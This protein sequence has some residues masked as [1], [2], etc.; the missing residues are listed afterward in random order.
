MVILATIGLTLLLTRKIA[1]P[2][3]AI[4]EEAKHLP[5]GEFNPDVR[6][7]QYREAAELNATL[8]QAAA[9]IKK[10]DKAKRDLI[11]NVS[12]APAKDACSG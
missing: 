5:S 9:D 4:N 11:A 1:K 8:T 3:T 2:L 12:H 10:A 7:S 6:N